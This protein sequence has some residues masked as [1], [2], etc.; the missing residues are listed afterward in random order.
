ME[1]QQCANN[2]VFFS[3]DVLESDDG[4]RIEKGRHWRKLDLMEDLILDVCS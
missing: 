1:F 2:V 4:N 3:Q